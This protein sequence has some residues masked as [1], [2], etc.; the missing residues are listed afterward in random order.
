MVYLSE[1][2]SSMMEEKPVRRLAERYDPRYGNGLTPASAIL[3]K[4]IVVFWRR[5]AK[6]S[7]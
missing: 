4:D 5:Y 3:V 7:S 6:H 2:F 1:G